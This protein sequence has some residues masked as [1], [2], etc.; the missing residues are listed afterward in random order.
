MRS[1]AANRSKGNEQQR[2]PAVMVTA[3]LK[4]KPLLLLTFERHS[5]LIDAYLFPHYKR[6]RHFFQMKTPHLSVP[7]KHSAQ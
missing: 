1:R 2:Q 4:S 7:L 5:T 6:S 3:H